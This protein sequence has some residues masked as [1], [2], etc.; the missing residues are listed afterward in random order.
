MSDKIKEILK[1]LEAVDAD[2]FYDAME[3]GDDDVQDYIDRFR[4]AV[5]EVAQILSEPPRVLVVQ[6]FNDDGAPEPYVVLPPH[7]MDLVEAD[8]KATAI[9]LQAAE[10][11]VAAGDDGYGEMMAFLDREF[12]EAGFGIPSWNISTADWS[13]TEEKLRTES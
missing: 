11:C 13:I 7:G 8:E 4:G 12:K 5:H 10:K 2:I 9:V 1:S 3:H 6:G